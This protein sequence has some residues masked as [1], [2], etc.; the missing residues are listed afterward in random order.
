MPLNGKVMG[1]GLLK[2]TECNPIMLLSLVYVT[3]YNFGQVTSNCN[4]LH[5]ESSLPN[6]E[7]VKL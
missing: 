7:F 1:K 4:G 6:P 5:L 3:V 2:V